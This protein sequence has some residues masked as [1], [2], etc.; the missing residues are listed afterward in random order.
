MT[1]VYNVLMKKQDKDRIVLLP[2][3]VSVYRFIEKYTKKN[4]VSPSIIE[5]SEELGI[6]TRHVYRLVDDLCELGALSKLS[7]KQRSI[8]IEKDI[9][10]VL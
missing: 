10:E 3:H 4:I 7:Y 2:N 6:A 9:K 1:S 8:K 5:I